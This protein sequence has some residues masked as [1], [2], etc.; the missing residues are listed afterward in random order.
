VVEPDEQ[1]PR[2]EDFVRLW[3]AHRIQLYSFVFSL[4]PDHVEAE[5]VFQCV[6][7]VLWNKFDQF[8]LGTNFWHWAARVAQ[9]EVQDYRKRKTRERLKFWSEEV[10]DAI[11][12]AHVE[13]SELLQHQ[14]RALASCLEKLSP[15]D[16]ELVALRYGAERITTKT[17]ADRL[18]RPLVTLYK[19]LSRIRRNLYQCIQRSLAREQRG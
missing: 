12:A 7:I 18:G 16:R 10:I 2:H 5:D 8:Q 3:S 19:A 6:S 1:P 13:Y 14:Q 11:A 9:L 4:L 17:L 15:R